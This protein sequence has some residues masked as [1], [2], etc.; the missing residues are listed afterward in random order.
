LKI[1]DLGPGRFPRWKSWPYNEE[2]LAALGSEN[3]QLVCVDRFGKKE[4]LCARKYAH[5]GSNRDN[6][7]SRMLFL[8]DSRP[9]LVDAGIP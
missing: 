2:F 4:Q 1:L 6:R 7:I 3:H 5:M 9:I 8:D